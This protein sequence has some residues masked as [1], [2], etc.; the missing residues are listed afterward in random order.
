MKISFFL[1]LYNYNI[2]SQ[3]ELNMNKLR[4]IYEQK[5]NKKVKEMFWG[6]ISF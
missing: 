4:N 6:N 2:P 1:F 3:Y 5:N